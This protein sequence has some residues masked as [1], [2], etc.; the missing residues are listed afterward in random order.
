MSLDSGTTSTLP[1]A[2]PVFDAYIWHPAPIQ[3]CLHN[4]GMN[5]KVLSDRSSE[6]RNA[7]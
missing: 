4:E 7:E 3:R 1:R 5:V 6:A 2:L